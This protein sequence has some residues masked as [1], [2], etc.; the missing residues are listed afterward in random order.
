MED[1]GKYG[2]G[3]SLSITARITFSNNPGKLGVI[4][5]SSLKLLR[6]KVAD[7]EPLRLRRLAQYDFAE[8]LELELA[9]QIVGWQP[10]RLR[11]LALGDRTLKS[12]QIAR[13]EQGPKRLLITHRQARRPDI[14]GHR[15]PG[16]HFRQAPRLGLDA[17]RLALGGIISQGALIDILSLRVRQSANTQNKR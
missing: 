1:A 8:L 10:A 6:C 4:G 5:D 15:P 3:V 14:L 2:L 11:S 16:V 9:K 12:I 13:R 7:V 17:L